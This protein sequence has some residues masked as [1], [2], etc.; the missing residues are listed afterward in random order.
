MIFPIGLED[1]HGRHG[2]FVFHFS[3]Q[4]YIDPE[5]DRQQN[6]GGK[7]GT[8]QGIGTGKIQQGDNEGGDI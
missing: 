4:P 8:E 3:I 2:M 7:A 1:V 6:R 5:K